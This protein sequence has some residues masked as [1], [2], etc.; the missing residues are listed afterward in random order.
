[1]N[2]NLVEALDLVRQMILFTGPNNDLATAAGRSV[3]YFHYM[4]L[5]VVGNVVII[6]LFHLLGTAI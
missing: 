4:F 2:A 1:M 6:I 5:F 3:N